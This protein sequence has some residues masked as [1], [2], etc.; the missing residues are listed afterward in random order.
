MAVPGAL[1]YS[2]RN[3]A[4]ELFA[5]TARLSS[6]AVAAAIPPACR[7]PVETLPAPHR[8]GDDLLVELPAWQPRLLARH[9]VPAFGA[10]TPTPYSVRFEL[11]VEAAPGW[12]G[13]VGTATLGPAEFGPIASVDDAV[14]SNVDLWQAKRPV[15]RIRMRVRLRADDVGALLEAP[16]LFTLSAWDGTTTDSAPVAGPVALRV[17]ALSQLAEG[18]AL[19]SRVCSPTSVAMV[20]GYW[21]AAERVSV[22][23][24]EMFHPALDLFGVWPAAIR[25][26][27]RRGV[28]GYLLRFPDWASAA[29][30]LA[31]GVPIVA[32]VRYA[33]GELPGA[34]IASTPGHL[35]VLTGYEDDVV[36]V[37]DPAAPNAAT[38]PRRYPLADL[39]RIWLTRTGVGYVL[40]GG[41]LDGPLRDLPHA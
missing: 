25:A 11:A 33:S 39:A 28:V 17:P 1:L 31:R 18:G 8:E 30:C 16:W 32:S 36:L 19:G 38:V 2:S 21:N 22:L 24:A 41:G 14:E 35:L 23:A 10:I 4:T 34:A 3:V 9:L 13:W 40:F 26:A 7:R 37:N 27:A 6:S 15:Q 29:W 12:S 5:A 20:L